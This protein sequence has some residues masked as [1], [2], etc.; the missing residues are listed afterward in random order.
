M[1]TIEFRSCEVIRAGGDKVSIAL[2]NGVGVPTCVA[3]LECP[4]DAA[5]ALH[6]RLGSVLGSRDSEI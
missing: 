6:A 3:I 5:A 4:I 2:F 1:D